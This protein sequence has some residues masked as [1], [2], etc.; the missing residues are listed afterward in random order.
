MT[1]LQ[2]LATLSLV[3]YTVR[4]D[5]WLA[6]FVTGLR[7]DERRCP[8]CCGPF[9]EDAQRKVDG[10]V[11][12]SSRLFCV[13]TSGYSEFNP[14]SLGA[15]LDC[16]AKYRL[17]D[18]SPRTELARIP[19]QNVA[20]AT[21]NRRFFHSRTLVLVRPVHVHPHAERWVNLWW[22]AQVAED[23]TSEECVFETG[24]SEIGAL[25]FV[26]NLVLVV[27]VLLGVFL[28]HVAA[29]SGVEALWL[30]KVKACWPDMGRQGR[31]CLQVLLLSSGVGRRRI[32]ICVLALRKQQTAVRWLPFWIFFFWFENTTR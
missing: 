17:A 7:C 5:S 13:S 1:Q 19:H 4:E 22:P 24:A 15:R 30:T 12:R 31:V 27:G 29:I 23:I 11:A 21:A 10:S 3:D 6:D 2:F 18:P 25:V 32:H 26:G 16:T 28:L 14:S 9:A 20:P 8:F